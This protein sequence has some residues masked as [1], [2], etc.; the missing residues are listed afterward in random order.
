MQ[1]DKKLC[2][3]TPGGESHEVLVLQCYLRIACS[4][5]YAFLAGISFLFA[6]Y[7]ILRRYCYPIAKRKYIH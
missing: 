7:V 3:D 4:A 5:V 1:L 6:L 2:Y